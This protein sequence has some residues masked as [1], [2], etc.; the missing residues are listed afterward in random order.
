ML[1]K[2]RPASLGRDASARPSI[3]PVRPS[4]PPP[5]PS[6]PRRA[7]SEAITQRNEERGEPATIT[8]QVEPPTLSRSPDT[9][10]F[11]DGHAARA[12]ADSLSFEDET[13]ARAVDNGLL[14]RLRRGTDGLSAPL[15]TPMHAPADLGVDYESLPSLE[16]RR[17]YDTYEGEFAERDP[18]TQLHADAHDARTHARG[19]QPEPESASVRR[20]KEASYEEPAYREPSY[21]A[22][23]PSYA[24]QNNDVWGRREESGPRSRPVPPPASSYAAP[25]PAYD[26]ASISAQWGRDHAEPA[27]DSWVP[28][29]APANDAYYEQ[30]QIPPAPR[31]PE[32]MHPAFVVGVQ[33]IRTATPDAWGT[34]HAAQQGQYVP[35]P[36][37]G[38]QTIQGMPQMQMQQMQQ[39]QMQAMQQQ[40]QQPAHYTPAP[41]NYQPA[42][43]Q[44]VHPS[45]LPS[46]PAGSYL[47]QSGPH[48]RDPRYM[49]P[50]PMHRSGM[51]PAMGDRNADLAAAPSTAAR[52]GRFAWFVAGAA[53]GITFAFFAT[54]FFAGAAP[55]DEF[56]AAPALTA[57]AAQAPA[58]VQAPAPAQ[59]A[60]PVAA[61][62][63]APVATTVAA[64][65]LPVAP[66]V[67]APAPPVALVP[68][69]ALPAAAPVAPPVAA[70]L[71]AVPPVAAPPPAAPAAPVAAA[72]A[73]APPA[74]RPAPPSRPRFQAPPPRRPAAP[75]SQAPKNLGGGG[76]GADDE[77]TPPSAPAGSDFSDLLGAGLKP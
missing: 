52:V 19:R 50:V 18:V 27:P 77:R 59:V 44:H 15:T 8:G 2:F 64:A 39:M 12:Q 58:P 9:V 36:M 14:D 61:A 5:P 60:P 33:P 17:P 32:E 23:A 20:A 16:V 28:E 63:A 41:P 66:P 49:T 7:P 69:A 67:A 21:P 55:K 1:P 25:V 54:G 74:A 57:P 68:A 51:A 56:P 10:P 42:H 45:A 4:P 48:A 71:A 65:A 76:P 34:P 31:V 73:V 40:Y 47:Q 72:A 38:M 46:Q 70:P 11:D 3:R 22:P 53:F 29:E 75:V 30:P 24:D 13:Q 26:D 62:P 35:Q 6:P 43:A 37:Q